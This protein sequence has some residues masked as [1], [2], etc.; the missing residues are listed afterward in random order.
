MTVSFLSV[1]K[2]TALANGIEPKMLKQSLIVKAAAASANLGQPMFVLLKTDQPE[3]IPAFVRA[4]LHGIP[5]E[6][7]EQA[8]SNLKPDTLFEKAVLNPGTL[9]SANTVN[10]LHDEYVSGKRKVAYVGFSPDD[11]PLRKQSNCLVVDLDV[12]SSHMVDAYPRPFFWGDIDPIIPT[13][14]LQTNFNLIQHINPTVKMDFLDEAAFLV[15][16]NYYPISKFSPERIALS[17]ALEVIAKFNVPFVTSLNEM[18]QFIDN[19]EKNNSFD[20]DSEYSAF[21]LEAISGY[22]KCSQLIDIELT[23]RQNE[24]YYVLAELEKERSGGHT[25][26]E[27]IQTSIAK[28][29]ATVLGG[30]GGNKSCKKS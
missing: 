7:V 1:L 13:I 10:K 2:G 25:V 14:C 29:T 8:D 17:R 3:I 26:N 4:S 5:S 9:L 22:L 30:D 18:K 27:I 15:G 11:D 6:W 28:V 23:D 16:S 19:F 20:L 21:A 24:F 12:D